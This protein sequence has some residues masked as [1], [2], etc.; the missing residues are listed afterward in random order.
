M[1]AELIAVGSEL[2][3]AGCRDTNTEWLA[4][5]L[6]WEEIPVALPMEW[7]DRRGTEAGPGGSASQDGAGTGIAV[8]AER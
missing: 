7:V 4:Q 8:S 1:N 3:Q 6:D 2:L 5:R